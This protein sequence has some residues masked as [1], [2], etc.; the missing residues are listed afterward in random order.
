MRRGG[1][2][3]PE[4]ADP[5]LIPRRRGQQQV[6]GDPLGRGTLASQGLGGRRVPGL[7]LPGRKILIQRRAHDRVHEPQALS[8]EEDVRSHQG[9]CRLSGLVLA[10]ARH[11]AGQQRLAVISEH[12]DRSRQL[13]RRG[14]E[15]SEP[16]Q[17]ETAHYGRSHVLHCARRS[18]RRH[19]LGRGQSSQQLP[20]EERVPPVAV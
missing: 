14:T 19:H 7:A 12:G 2:S 9:I 3:R 20:Q 15:R 1:R 4:R 6:R 16:V 10:Q 8:R 17:D 13:G 5:A 18:R 11:P